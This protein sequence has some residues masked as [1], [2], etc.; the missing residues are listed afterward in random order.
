MKSSHNDQLCQRRL[1]YVAPLSVSVITLALLLVLSARFYYYVK[2]PNVD[3]KG[4]AS[5][6]IYIPTGADF[7][8]LLKILKEK[9]ILKN[10]RSFI[11]VAGRKHYMNRVKAGKY[12]IRDRISNNE[13][14]SQLRSG[15]QEPVRLSFQ[16]ARNIAELASKLGR[17]IEADSASL[18]KLFLNDDFLKKYGINTYNVF[19]LFIPNTYEI[20]W[21]TSATQLIEKMSLEQKA[22]WNVKRRKQLDEKGLNIKEVVTIASI[23]EKE[24][25]KDFEK[26]DI[27]GVYINRLRKGWPLQAD[28]TVIYAW[29]DYSIKRLSGK[30]LKIQSGYNTYLHT[31]LPPGPICIPSVSTIDAVLNYRAHAYMYFCAKDDLSGSHNFA[32]NIAEHG[33]NAR[34][35]QKALDRLNIK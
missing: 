14:V 33:R 4:K 17:Q 26:P 24:T 6:I 35:Y 28:P 31:G 5:V 3:L 32:V 30:H 34:K 2:Y 8:G 22:F 9:S 23:V 7:N 27:A 16:S 11:F 18:M 10:E 15:R 29:Q 25:N 19:V 20:F 21:N 13:L 12:R 1:S